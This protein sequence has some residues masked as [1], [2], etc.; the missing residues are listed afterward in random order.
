MRIRTPAARGRR[1]RLDLASG[2]CRSGDPRVEA[3]LTKGLMMKQEELAEQLVTADDIERAALLK[4]HAALLNVRLAHALKSLF[5][6]SKNSDP[7]RAGRAVAALDALSHSTNHLEITALAHWTG[8]IFAL[9]IDGQA[10]RAI[11]GLDQA[12]ALFAAIDQPLM[13]GATQVSKLHALAILGR[14]DEALECG[15]KARD[16]FVAHGDESAAGK[17]EHNLGNIY[18]RRDAYQQ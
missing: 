17:I 11:A 1:V 2:S 16:I 18:F 12:A 4:R 14:Y 8:G 10:E 3:G 9:L 7:A 13:A 15:I 5:D 6:D